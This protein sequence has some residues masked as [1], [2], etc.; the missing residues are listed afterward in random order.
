MPLH[1]SGLPENALCNLRNEIILFFGAGAVDVKLVDSIID[2]TVKR[3]HRRWHPPW[4]KKYVDIT[5]PYT[6]GLYSLPADFKKMIRI[7]N[8]ADAPETFHEID[9]DYRLEE[10]TS[11]KTDPR[12]Q[13][14]W[15]PAITTDLLIRAWY[16]R[17][18]VRA[19]DDNDLVEIEPDACDL[20]RLGA[21]VYIAS[22]SGDREDYL[23]YRQEFEAELEKWIDDDTEPDK[24]NV[25]LPYFADGTTIDFEQG[26]LV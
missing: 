17:K 2:D 22:R 8:Q 15:I 5:M 4:A 6:T 14:K 21:R 12:R 3:I 25:S 7:T 18:P 10:F 24:K 9:I 11:S 19:V 23:S 13:L 26:E 1:D 16:Y 20:I